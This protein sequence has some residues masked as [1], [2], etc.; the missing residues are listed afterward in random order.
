MT[1]FKSYLRGALLGTVFALLFM[2]APVVIDRRFANVPAAV[3]LAAVL[4]WIGNK[5]LEGLTAVIVFAWVG[6]LCS[7]L[8]DA[9][10]FVGRAISARMAPPTGPIALEEGTAIP[11]LPPTADDT[12]VSSSPAAAPKNSPLTIGQKLISIS[13]STYFLVSQI[14]ASIRSNT[15]S[16]DRPILE[17][18][19]VGLKYMLRGCE[20]IFALLLVLMLVAAV[21]QQWSGSASPAPAQSTPAPVQVLVSVDVHVAEDEKAAIKE[22]EEAVLV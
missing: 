7:L 2:I 4:R 18:V 15:I 11:P 10:R 1:F 17:N 3:S 13:S 16:F 22:E 20:V 21:K 19:W 14:R 9:R 6:V 8:N 5:G 12:T